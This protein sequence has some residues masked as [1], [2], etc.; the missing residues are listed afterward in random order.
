MVEEGESIVDAIYVRMGAKDAIMAGQSTFFIELNETA[1]VLRH[2]TEHSLVALDELGRGT[3]TTD[4]RAI[5]GAVMEHILEDLQCRTLFST[6]YR[7]LA[8]PLKAAGRVAV[9]H[10]GCSVGRANPNDED[11]VPDVA[12]LYKLTDGAAPSS[13]GVN[14]ARLAGIPRNI[15]C[16]A[17]RSSER[18]L[19]GAA[20]SAGEVPVP[21]ALLTSVLS[22]IG[23]GADPRSAPLKDVWARAQ[24]EVEKLSQ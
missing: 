13:Y 19:G 16:G 23:S 12:F 22:A 1:A 15:L 11:A 7:S 4:G 5:A 8:D 14:V 2:A 10:M 18:I 3:A 20:R 9:K 24:G 17:L 21:A 6:H